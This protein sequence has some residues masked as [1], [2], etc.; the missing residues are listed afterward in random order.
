M[1]RHVNRIQEHW[2]DGEYSRKV[3]AAE[4]GA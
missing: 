2:V 3:V 4:D 1:Q